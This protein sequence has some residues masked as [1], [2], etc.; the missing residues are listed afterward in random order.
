MKYAIIFI[1]KVDAPYVWKTVLSAHDCFSSCQIVL[2][3][4]EA[5]TYTRGCVKCDKLSC[6]GF[7][8]FDKTFQI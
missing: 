6:G 8:V 5:K 2:S 7:G 1:R 4:S 3:V